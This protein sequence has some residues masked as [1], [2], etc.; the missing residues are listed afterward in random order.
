[1]SALIVFDWN[2]FSIKS[3]KVGLMLDKVF[4]S[5]ILISNEDGIVLIDHLFPDFF[6]DRL[7]KDF[8]YFDLVDNVIVLSQEDDEW[9]EEVDGNEEED[10]R[11]TNYDKKLHKLNI[12]TLNNCE[13]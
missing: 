1:M 7:F 9:D 6:I 3:L 5:W 12:K 13:E 2:G 10:D 11:W 4:N 8:I